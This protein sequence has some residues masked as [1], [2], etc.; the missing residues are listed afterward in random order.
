MSVYS[1]RYLGPML[2]RHY[3]TATLLV[4]MNYDHFKST[5]GLAYEGQFARASST[6]GTQQAAHDRCT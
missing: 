6:L 4:N 2:A 3:T 5:Y 1:S